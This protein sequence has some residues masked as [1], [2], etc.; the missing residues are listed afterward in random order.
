MMIARATSVMVAGAYIAI[1]IFSKMEG[2]ILKTIMFLILPMA[3]IWYGDA[4]G[5]YTGMMRGQYISKTSPGCLVAACGWL[6]LMLPILIK[7][8]YKP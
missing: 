6:M 2:A 8:I 3:C 7:L 5:T 4:M 1:A